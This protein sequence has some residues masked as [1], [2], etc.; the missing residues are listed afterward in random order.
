MDLQIHFHYDLINQSGI[1]VSFILIKSF[2]VLSWICSLRTDTTYT[3]FSILD[4]FTMSTIDQLETVN[5]FLMRKIRTKTHFPPHK[6]E[7]STF[8]LIDVQCPIMNAKNLKPLCSVKIYFSVSCR[9]SLISRQVCKN[10]EC[11]KS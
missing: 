10:F 7:Q 6:S 1:L 4:L 9:S 8:I 11:T 3:F 2:Q 5:N